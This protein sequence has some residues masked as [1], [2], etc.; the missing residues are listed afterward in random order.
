MASLCLS[1]QF[2]WAAKDVAERPPTVGN[3]FASFPIVNRLWPPRLLS[4]GGC[5]RSVTDAAWRR[6]VSGRLRSGR[7][8][9]LRSE[10]SSRGRTSWHRPSS[11]MAAHRRRN[12]HA[13]IPRHV[14]GTACDV[15]SLGGGSDVCL[16]KQKV[17]RP[18]LC[19]QRVSVVSER[20]PDETAVVSSR[21]QPPSLW[22]QRRCC[23]I[24]HCRQGS[25]P[26]HLLR[27]NVVVMVELCRGGCDDVDVDLVV[28]RLLPSRHPRQHDDVAG[29]ARARRR[30]KDLE[31]ARLAQLIDRRLQARRH[32]ECVAAAAPDKRDLDPPP[33]IADADQRLRHNANQRLF[34]M[35]GC[36]GV[37][38]ATMAVAERQNITP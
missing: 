36:L 6:A 25:C 33:D 29:A 24:C 9:L 16:V 1:S 27:N 13:S 38:D 18:V 31:L 23:R 19:P 8:S 10:L 28:E 3:R 32:R 17:G 22:P 15:T 20:R 30:D 37:D 7:G 5:R 35:R 11:V 34:I 26:P 12:M 4:S 14:L 2:N 21:S